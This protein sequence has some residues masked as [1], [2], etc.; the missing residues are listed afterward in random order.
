M[1]RYLEC[2]VEQPERTMEKLVRILSSEAPVGL[3]FHVVSAS[4]SMDWIQRRQVRL[5]PRRRHPFESDAF[6]SHC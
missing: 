2:H 6:A 3:L 4:E 5:L 1:H